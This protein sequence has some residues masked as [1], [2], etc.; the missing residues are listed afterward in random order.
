MESPPDQEARCQILHDFST[1]LFVEASAGSGK[2]HSL[3]SR[4]VEG[5]AVGLVIASETAV[6][7]FTRK[8]AA[9]LRGRVRLRLE[10][11]SRDEIDPK[12]QENLSN[13]ITNL[14]D[15][16]IGTIHSF[17][18]R[19]LREHPVAAGVSPGFLESDEV[20]DVRLRLVV[21]RNYLESA[22]GMRLVSHL[23]EAQMSPRDLH[24]AL[25]KVCEY[26]EVEF[27]CEVIA[28]PDAKAGW[29]ALGQFAAELEPLLPPS[30]A[31]DSKCGIQDTADRFLRRLSKVR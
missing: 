7:T 26:S 20:E 27:P 1:N 13:A 3:V 25:A 19:L 24:D 12:R 17:C 29:E 10:S 11:L 14:G 16:F 23:S 31:K 30:L 22:E 2:T 6:V 4:I 28:L 9:E 18:G 5:L 8:A 15:M 21:F